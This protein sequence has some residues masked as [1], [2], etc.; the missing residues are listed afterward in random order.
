MTG[1]ALAIVAPRLLFS[2]V[3]VSGIQP[4]AGASYVGT[5]G[6]PDPGTG[7]RL[8]MVFACGV[9]ASAWAAQVITERADIK[10]RFLLLP[11]PIKVIPYL[12]AITL[13]LTFSSE[14]PK[15][16]IYFQF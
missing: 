8:Y 12:A 3:S 10:S 6:D 4:S 13:V 14:T 2:S 1:L 7:A 11:I 9:M 5:L 15:S 16:F